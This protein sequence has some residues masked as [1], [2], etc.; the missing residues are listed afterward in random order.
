MVASYH[1]LNYY[2]LQDHYINLFDSKLHTD[3]RNRFLIDSR[4]YADT[5]CYYEMTDPRYQPII[6]NDIFYN[7]GLL[8]STDYNHS[9]YEILI[10]N[11]DEVSENSENS[12]VSENSEISQV[13]QCKLHIL[14]DMINYIQKI[15]F[16]ASYRK[17][18]I[19]YENAIKQSNVELIENLK[20]I[21]L[22]K[23][24]H[25]LTYIEYFVDLNETIDNFKKSNIYDNHKILGKI[26]EKIFVKNIIK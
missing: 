15:W 23:F 13:N 12:E 22:N 11:H 14:Y 19:E 2:H 24:I 21:I 7:P 8:S 20:S 16:D 17:N 4:Y 25:I 1:G 10:F 26:I 6:I 5:S 3:V 18:R 9:L